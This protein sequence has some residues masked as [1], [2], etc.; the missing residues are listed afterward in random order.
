MIESRVFRA[1]QH[2]ANSAGIEECEAWKLEQKLHAER[3]AIK[4]GGAGNVLHDESDL[5]DS[6]KRDCYRGRCHPVLLEMITS[7]SSARPWCR[8]RPTGSRCV[9]FRPQRAG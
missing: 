3:V 2:E 5:A 8:S 1:G 4:S 9:R 6:S 7:S